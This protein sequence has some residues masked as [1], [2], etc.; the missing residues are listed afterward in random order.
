LFFGKVLL[1]DTCSRQTIRFLNPKY[2]ILNT[3]QIQMI[4]AQNSKQFDL[5][6][7]TNEVAKRVRMFVKQSFEHLEF[8]F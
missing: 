5:E 4:K 8:E 6:D 3:K 1:Q 2:E 7:Q